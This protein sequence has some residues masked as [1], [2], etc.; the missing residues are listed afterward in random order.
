MFFLELFLIL[1]EIEFLFTFSLSRSLSFSVCVGLFDLKSI[2][3][4]KTNHRLIVFGFLC[5]SF[6][7]WLLILLPRC[8][9][10][11]ICCFLQF[12]L[13]HYYCYYNCYWWFGVQ[14]CSFVF[15]TSVSTRDIYLEFKNI[16]KL[17]YFDFTDHWLQNFPTTTL[18]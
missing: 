9:F 14:R 16:E 10:R 3:G 8:L 12:N 5:L 13:Y 6:E 17:I 1:D 7:L 11:L 18:S 15:I 2:S 4:P